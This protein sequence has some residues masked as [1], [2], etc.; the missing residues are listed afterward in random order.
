MKNSFF[1]IIFLFL[2]SP[3]TY[4]ANPTKVY[5]QGLSIESFK[6][7]VIIETGASQTTLPKIG[8]KLLPG[9]KIKTGPESNIVLVSKGEDRYQLGEN[10]TLLI[11][12]PLK[13]RLSLLKQTSNKKVKSKE[14]TL[15]FFKR[16]LD[17]AYVKPGAKQNVKNWHSHQYSI[18]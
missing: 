1:I 7:I 6:S 16:Q 17:V 10:S 14:E 4:G 8:L 9:T 2:L 3:I 11:S 13:D 12:K 18:C 5:S 15:Q